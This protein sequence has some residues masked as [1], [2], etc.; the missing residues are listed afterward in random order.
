MDI[1]EFL[2]ILY[3]ISNI[4][5]GLKIELITLFES[6]KDAESAAIFARSKILLQMLY[7]EICS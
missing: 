4:E 1:R 5:P 7:K 6:Q 3:N 2:K